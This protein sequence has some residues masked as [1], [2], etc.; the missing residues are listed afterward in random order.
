MGINHFFSFLFSFFPLFGF[1]AF[2]V[3]SHRPQ[4]P[5][6]QP[7]THA[8]ACK[9]ALLAH[10]SPFFFFF[11]FESN[12]SQSLKI[13]YVLPCPSSAPYLIIFERKA[14]WS[15]LSDRLL[16]WQQLYPRVSLM[17]LCCLGSKMLIVTIF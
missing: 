12:C 11:G 10:A 13:V 1:L 15:R 9:L 14:G 17:S 7:I 4:K 5:P 3:Y 6:L 16:L 8:H 2:L